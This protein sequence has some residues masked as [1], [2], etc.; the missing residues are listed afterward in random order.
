M[1]RKALI[2]ILLVL[3]ALAGYASTFIVSYDRI[4][5]PP[6]PGRFADL[7]HIESAIVHEVV[8]PR[9]VE[10][11][12]ALLQ[13]ARQK[14][15]KVSI[16]GSR[17]S[18][19]GHIVYD[20]ALVVDMRDFVEVLAFDPRRKVIRVEAGATWDDVQRYVAPRGLAVK[21]MQSSNIFTVGGTLSANAHGRD[22]DK[23]S[24]VETVRSLRL[25]TADGTIVEASRDRNA[26][27]FRLV[28]GGYGM[29]GVIL[30]AEIELTDDEVYEQR[31]TLV[32]Y[33]DFPRHFET[34]VKTDPTV[35]LMLARPSIDRDDFLRT[36]VVTTWHR[37]EERPVGVFALSEERHVWRD[38]FLFGLSRTFD[39]AKDLRWALQKRLEL[40][41]GEK[42]IMSRNNA[43][44]PP[45]APLE[46]LDHYS[47]SNTDV[48]QE[49][50][51]PTRNFVRFMNDL[52]R[53]LTEGEMNVLS[54]TIR[55]VRANDEVALPYAPREDAFA[56]IHMSNV[57]LSPE[58][59][60]GARAVTRRIVDA[61][62]AAGGTYY[63]TYQ[64]Y[65]TRDQLVSAYP[66]AEEVF[67]RKRVYD[68]Q[69]LFM[70]RFYATYA[71]PAGG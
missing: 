5:R 41:V 60:A 4:F 10:Q 55:Y 14:R 1:F 56:I 49:Y 70:S 38:R 45:L 59:Q 46:L 11:L 44:R 65:P 27:L 6:A 16:S 71:H 13:E 40:G 66:R 25:L 8:R 9:K 53:L 61:A 19:G 57:G 62:I 22:L 54:A 30:D 32:D 20:D 28:V 34:A 17:H 39:W 51:V 18:Q 69:E 43:M 48:I 29:F 33:R 3:V 52:R 63:L 58:A 31:S 42:R 68:P 24:V 36:I 47:A 50:F 12:V 26:E 67:A 15:L 37:T 21:V 35:A 23:T 7:A 2:A 64:L